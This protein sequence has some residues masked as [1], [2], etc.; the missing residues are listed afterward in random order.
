[1]KANDSTL[2]WFTMAITSVHRRLTP[3]DYDI[4]SALDRCPLTVRQIMKL[5]ETFAERSFTSPRSVQDRLQKLHNAG[6]VR[7]WTF[8]TASRSGAPDYAK[9]TLVGYRLLY[10]EKAQPPTKRYL[11][12]VGIAHQHHTHCLAEF[13]VHTAVAAHRQGIA[14]KAFFR[15][16]TLRLEV[17]LE[18][19]FPD[20]AFDLVV[21]D[22]QPYRFY[23]ELDNGTERVRSEKETESWQ[24]KIRLY[25]QWQDRIAPQRF[26]VLVVT[27]RTS[28]RLDYIL[29]LASQHASNPKRSLFYAIHLDDYLGRENA[30]VDDCFRDHRGGMTSL[31]PASAL[32]SVEPKSSSAV[33]RTGNV[34]NLPTATRPLPREPR[35][36]G[37]P[38]PTS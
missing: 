9:L 12:E 20:A 23:V 31:V 36:S 30:I 24:R 13:I 26:R 32:P 5:S 35:S 27:T 6:W 4:L 33:V 38:S 28:G 37:L 11:K 3:R 10:G 21:A 1:M 25:E 7:R 15:E 8:A 34:P 14:M 19:L 17:A 29:D 16:N 2:P 18:S 22:G